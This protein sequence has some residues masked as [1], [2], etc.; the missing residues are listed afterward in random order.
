[1]AHCRRCG[2]SLRRCGGS[3]LEMWWLI[4]TR[5]CGGSL[6]EMW[7]LIEEMWGLIIGDVVAHCN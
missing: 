5:R 6:K 4:V 2:G 1:M 7:W 3:L